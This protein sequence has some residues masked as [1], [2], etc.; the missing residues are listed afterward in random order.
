M[1]GSA[2][3]LHPRSDHDAFDLVD[4][5]R[6][7]RP[8][9]ELRRLR[10]RV[11]PRL[12][13]VLRSPGA[14]GVNVLVRSASRTPAGGRTSGSTAAAGDGRA[15]SG[16]PGG[17]RPR[18]C[19]ELGRGGRRDVDAGGETGVREPHGRA[20]RRR[21]T[22]PPDPSATASAAT[23]V[24]GAKTPD[25]PSSRPKW[26]RC[27]ALTVGRI[28]RGSVNLMPVGMAVGGDGSTVVP[29][30]RRAPARAA[31]RWDELPTSWG[32]SSSVRP[33]RRSCA[34]IPPSSPRPSSPGASS[35]T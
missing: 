26:S 29:G 5:H 30:P 13:G 6:V 17:L 23:G 24:P 4:G 7:R 9:V 18:T 22:G 35:A 14:G 28:K 19:D 3:N 27:R 2:S 21:P 33:S 34:P 20:R 32:P 31:A 1:R 15:G 10:R 16:P 8:V 12:L 11:P 25:A